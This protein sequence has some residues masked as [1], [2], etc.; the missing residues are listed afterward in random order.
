[1]RRVFAIPET[2]V[3]GALVLIGAYLL[4]DAVS[5]NSPTAT[6]V[7]IS[8]AVLMVFG[9]GTLQAVVRSIL[10]HR[11]MLRRA[12]NSD[13]LQESVDAPG[14]RASDSGS[15]MAEPQ[16]PYKRARAAKA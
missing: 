14:V 10:W 5:S 2:V 16:E 15:S 4:G 6:P 13:Q 12:V 7:L 9:I 8:G 11:T 3:C 1:M